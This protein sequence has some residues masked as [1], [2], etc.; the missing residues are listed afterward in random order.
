MKRVIASAILVS[1]IATACGGDPATPSSTEGRDVAGAPTRKG[2]PKKGG[3]PKAST[4]K[5]SKT[6][7]D[8]GR[9]NARKKR[10]A[11]PEADGGA[12]TASS[13]GKGGRR[14]SSAD[15][16]RPSAGAQPAPVPIP[17]GTHAYAT[18]GRRTVS[19]NTQDLPETTTLEAE[20]AQGD[21]QRQTRDLRDGDGY[22][23]VTET[24]LIYGPQG[25]YLAYVKVTSSFPGGF[26]DVREF[27]LP[28]PVLI[29]PRGSGP[30]F[31]TSFTMEGSGTRADV[32]IAAVRYESTRIGGTPLRSLVVDT[33][34]SFSGALEGEQRSISW[35]WPKHLWAV[36]EQVH[37]DV[38]NGPIRLLSDYRAEVKQL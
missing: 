36:K 12:A 32:H 6:G 25:V 8:T 16:Q 1:L 9:A 38:R 17:A 18:D 27:R 24:H 2:V 4:D 23:T 34:I 31:E 29:A 28:D 11:S 22:G 19:G 5:T 26:T 14:V 13:E 10:E 37:T 7:G 30:G 3:P 35:Y 21:F 20:G 33:T 15:A